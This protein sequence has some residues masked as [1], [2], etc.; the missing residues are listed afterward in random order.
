MRLAI[1][2]FVVFFLSGFIGF[3]QKNVTQKPREYVELKVYHATDSSQLAVVDRYVQ[4][5]LFP[6]LEKAGFVKIGAFKAIDN[7]TAKDKRFYVLVSLASLAQLER[8][9]SVVDQSLTDT[10]TA[11]NYTNSAYN[12]PPYARFETILL[13]AFEGAPQVRPSGV[14]GDVNE[15]V[16]ELRSYESATE[17]LHRNKVKMFNSGEI[18]LFQRLG[19]NAVFY[20]QVIA[21]SQ[22]PN[23]MYMTTF[24][25]KTSR[26]EHWKT[27]GSDPT[28]KAM[29]SAPEYQ[30]N[31]SKNTSIFLRPTSYSRL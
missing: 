30:H 21:G 18:E 10:V 19:F 23:L 17:A 14:N 2:Y 31:V 20:G 24:T 29:S 22:M 6:A 7:D 13:R 11:H 25:N 12:A 9:N 27:F 26:D 8:L 5:S 28:W 16:Y 3:G 15:R 1:C 4:S